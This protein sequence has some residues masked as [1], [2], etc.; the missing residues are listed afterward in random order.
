MGGSSIVD[1]QNV[2]DP[3]MV[4]G[5]VTHCPTHHAPI[6]GLTLSGP[7]YSAFTEDRGPGTKV[8]VPLGRRKGMPWKSS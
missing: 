1:G 2:T 5:P 3:S 7:Y 4:R 6:D 8:A